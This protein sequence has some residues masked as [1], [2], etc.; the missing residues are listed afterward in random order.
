MTRRWKLLHSPNN[1]LSTHVNYLSLQVFIFIN[2]WTPFISSVVRHTSYTMKCLIALT[3][4]AVASASSVQL[5]RDEQCDCCT[6][7]GGC[8]GIGYPYYC[9]PDGRYCAPTFADCPMTCDGTPCP[10]GW[11]C[12]PHD[13]Y[14]YWT[15][16]FEC[17]YAHH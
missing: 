7:P 3:F 1:L 5:T 6:C 10:D 12:C 8:C 14:C 11:F 17:P 2:P 4:L 15:A 16:T 13:K 9:C